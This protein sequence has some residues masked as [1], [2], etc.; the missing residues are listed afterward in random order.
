MASWEVL[1]E[2]DTNR[3]HST[4][5]SFSGQWS[6][7][8][9]ARNRVV[10]DLEASVLESFAN[11]HAEEKPPENCNEDRETAFDG[12]RLDEDRI[13]NLGDISVI[14]A[15]KEHDMTP[16]ME[17]ESRIEYYSTNNAQWILATLQVKLVLQ[18]IN[19]VD[20]RS[21]SYQVTL[22]RTGQTRE[23]VMID[24][25]RSPFLRAE[26]VDIFSRRDGGVWIPGF[27]CGEPAPGAVTLGYSISLEDDGEILNNIL[28]GRLRRRFPPGCP[29]KVYRGPEVG[30]VQAVVPSQAETDS[31]AIGRSAAPLLPLGPRSP[32]DDDTHATKYWV[33]VPIIKEPA[34]L[35]MDGNVDPEWVPSYRVMLMNH[36]LS[37]CV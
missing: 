6:E 35:G 1:P 36:F 26:P 32:G 5:L 19:D 7:R 33:N 28:P 4:S 27:I 24:C 12:S 20:W 29:V 10:W 37:W 8:T 2:N 25:F 18:Q 13:V 3:L 17:G 15:I 23:D 9:S 11:A 34:Q 22:P 31:L 30:W 21:L 14:S 16:I